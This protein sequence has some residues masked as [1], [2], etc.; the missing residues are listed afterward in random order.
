[1]PDDVTEAAI[2]AAWERVSSDCGC[3]DIYFCPTSG[4]IECPRHGGFDVC[5]DAPTLHVSARK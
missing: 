5:C 3:P 2:A 4:D 1:M